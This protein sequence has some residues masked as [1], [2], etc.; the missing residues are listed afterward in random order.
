MYLLALSVSGSG[1]VAECA[2]RTARCCTDETAP[3]R[4]RPKAWRVVVANMIF[5]LLV[6]GYA[7][8]EAAAKVQR[9]GW[10][11]GCGK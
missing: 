8:V 7:Q 2:R 9:A 4:A 1:S 6:E 10:S 3:T 5:S 11:A